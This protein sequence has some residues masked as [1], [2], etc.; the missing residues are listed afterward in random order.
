MFEIFNK[1]GNILGATYHIYLR[2]HEYIVSRDPKERLS[3]EQLEEFLKSH[4]GYVTVTAHIVAVI[5]L[6]NKYKAIKLFEGRVYY[7]KD[8]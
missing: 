2:N 1:S 4:T 7:A 5:C 8:I 3:Q 6:K